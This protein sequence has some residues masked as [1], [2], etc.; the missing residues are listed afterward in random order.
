MGTSPLQ[1]EKGLE[2]PSSATQVAAEKQNLDDTA[3]NVEELS[4][5]NLHGVK[6]SLHSHRRNT[7]RAR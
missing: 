3:V 4:P 2:S 5:R 6:V 1:D 7:G